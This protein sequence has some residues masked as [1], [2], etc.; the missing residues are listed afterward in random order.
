MLRTL[1]VG[2]SALVLSTGIA[3]AE[4][5]PESWQDCAGKPWVDGDN[6]ET[7]LG[8]KWWPADDKKTL[9]CACSTY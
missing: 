7:P 5:S 9:Q 1:F 8:S 2:A 4:C 6:M 3:A